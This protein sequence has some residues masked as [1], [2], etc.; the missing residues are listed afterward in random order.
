MRSGR[1]EAMATKVHESTKLVYRFDEGDASMSSLLG[2][3]GSNLC[4]MVRLGLP[5]PPGFVISTETCREYFSLGHKLPKG[6]SEGIR[7]NIRLLEDSMGRKF[8]SSG[9]PLL[10]SVRSGAKISMPGMMDTIPESRY[11]RRYSSGISGRN[12]RPNALPLT[13]IVGSYKFTPM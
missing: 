5:I 7:E 12:G 11:Q 6:L 9:H 1:E 3:K 13:P 8:G 2:G 10:V 4:E